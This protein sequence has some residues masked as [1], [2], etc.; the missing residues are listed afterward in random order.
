MTRSAVPAIEQ[1]N[2]VVAR[3]NETKSGASLAADPAAQSGLLAELEPLLDLNMRLGEASGAATGALLSFSLRDIMLVWLDRCLSV[4][5]RHTRLGWVCA[6]MMF[7]TLHTLHKL[8]C[9]K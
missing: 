7:C 8:A 1:M 5:A 4:F 3:L 2:T 6:C 9:A